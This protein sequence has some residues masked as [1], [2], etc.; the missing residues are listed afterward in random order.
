MK[1]LYPGLPFIYDDSN[2]LVGLRNPDGTIYN[3]VLYL[4]IDQTPANGVKASLATNM[5]NANADITLTAVNY[6]VAGND[7]TV[8][9]V[10]PAGNNKALAVAV[11][12]KGITVSLAT[13]AGGAITS[14]CALVVDA[15]NASTA[16]SALVVATGEG[17][18]AGVVNAIAKA[19][20]ASGADVTPG[21][22]GCYCHTTDG[23]KVYRKTAAQ[24]WAVLV[25]ESV[26]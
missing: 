5:T 20:L 26:A 15:I 21:P 8:T 2:N 22:I 24:T 4:P 14:T 23:K 11:S 16:A 7:I 6:G 13:G 25:D 9:Y 1:Q 17:T 19:S 18:K 12:G 3:F 10:D